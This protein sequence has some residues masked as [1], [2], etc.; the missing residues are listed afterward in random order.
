VEIN[1]IDSA[2]PL[3]TE[4]S[5]SSSVLKVTNVTHVA[6]SLTEEKDKAILQMLQTKYYSKSDPVTGP[7]WPRGWVEV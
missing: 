7:V 3:L 2:Q 1:I 6:Y 4:S 5:H